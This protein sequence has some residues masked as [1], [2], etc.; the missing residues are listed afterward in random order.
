MKLFGAQFLIGRTRG[1]GGQVAFLRT[2]PQNP[3]LWNW[4]YSDDYLKVKLAY[5]SIVRVVLSPGKVELEFFFALKR[6]TGKTR[7]MKRKDNS[8]VEALFYEV[9]RV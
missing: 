6:T 8:D 9:L 2:S 5:G 1:E 4:N 3:W 7:K